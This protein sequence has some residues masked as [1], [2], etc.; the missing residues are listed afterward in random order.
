VLTACN[1]SRLFFI[2][3]ILMSTSL[4]SRKCW[5]HT[6]ALVFFLKFLPPLVVWRMCFNA[7]IFSCKASITLGVRAVGSPEM[8]GVATLEGLVDVPAVIGTSMSTSP[9]ASASDPL[10]SISDPWK[11][12]SSIMR[13]QHRM[14]MTHPR[15]T[16]RFYKVV[17]IMIG[18]NLK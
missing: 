12:R 5:I 8:A 3:V 11:A 2:L 15:G 10:S 4:V 6:W 9:S 18:Y 16:L 14:Y 17:T 1:C 7:S 13:Q